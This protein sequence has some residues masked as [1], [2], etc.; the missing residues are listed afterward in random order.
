MLAD[1]KYALRQLRKPT[2]FAA[3]AI[4]TLAIGIGAS[5]SPLDVFRSNHS[6]YRTCKK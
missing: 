5:L 3:T 6:T 1:L 4:V 2:G